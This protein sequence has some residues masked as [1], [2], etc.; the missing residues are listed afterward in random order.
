MP[1]LRTCH[2][3]YHS[4]L[5]INAP[6]P[7]TLQNGSSALVLPH[8]LQWH[9][10][11]E[12]RVELSAISLV[13]QVF[14]KPLSTCTSSLVGWYGFSDTHNASGIA[15]LWL[16]QICFQCDMRN[17]TLPVCSVGSDPAALWTVA[18]NANPGI[19][20]L[21]GRQMETDGY[22]VGPWSGTGAWELGD[23]F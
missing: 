4:V 11:L 3:S 18:Q 21:L 2:A 1:L 22:P 19:T 23:I 6:Q 15:E 17:A 9:L 14:F 5:L 8:I 7:H 12:S 10:F 13:Q 16:Q 20:G